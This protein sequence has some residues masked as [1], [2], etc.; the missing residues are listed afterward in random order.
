MFSRVIIAFVLA[1]SAALS[2]RAVI[3]VDPD[4]ARFG[5]GKTN[6]NVQTSTTAVAFSEFT[7][8]A[9]VDLRLGGTLIGA[10]LR[11]PLTG[12]QQALSL[13]SGGL[14]FESV[15]YSGEP[16]NAKGRLNN[17]YKETGGGNGNYT[18]EID[19]SKPSSPDYSV[20]FG[21][22]GDLYPA[23]PLL[24]L[25]NGAWNGSGQFVFDPASVTSL[26]WTFSGYNSAT[27]IIQLTIRNGNN[28][29]V[30]EEFTTSN[31]GEYSLSAN[32]LAPGQNYTAT[33]SFARVVE[34]NTTSVLGAQG[35]AF[36]A[37]E[38]R[39]DFVAVPEPSTYAL[40]ALGL[41]LVGVT[42]R[43]RRRT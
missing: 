27:D 13:N 37:T 5:V 8:S 25:N 24:T 20:S 41:G 10:T 4:I 1:S 35:L 16:T 6:T 14:D 30:R 23:T 12:G 2:A 28:T 40:L 38:T 33:L 15:T 17:D 7:F 42:L 29:I 31:P 11:G 26:G 21:L 9:F 18:L 19:T 43:R 34:L 36:F 39:F 3:L 32:A 22:S